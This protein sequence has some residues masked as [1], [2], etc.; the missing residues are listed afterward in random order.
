MP[1]CSESKRRRAAMKEDE[2]PH[3]PRSQLLLHLQ[4]LPG[5]LAYRSSRHTCYRAERRQKR[6][7][8]DHSPVVWAA[9]PTTRGSSAG[10]GRSGCKDAARESFLSARK[11][12]IMIGL[13]FLVACS[14]NLIGGCLK[15]LRRRV[16]AHRL[17]RTDHTQNSLQV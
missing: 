10:G 6:P 14:L 9:S 4:Q 8:E 12:I 2:E 11:R 7:G 3:L 16:W 15:E 13:T 5:Y 1:R 17:L